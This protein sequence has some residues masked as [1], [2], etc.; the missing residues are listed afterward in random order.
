MEHDVINDMIQEREARRSELE[1]QLNALDGEIRLLKEAKARQER[2]APGNKDDAPR[3]PAA[4]AASK[5]SRNLKPMWADVMREIGRRGSAS[6]DE[7]DVHNREQGHNIKRGTL[8]SQLSI[9]VS[10][11]WLERNDSEYRLTASGAE[12]CDFTPAVTLGSTNHL[13]EK[14]EAPAD[15]GASSKE[16]PDELFG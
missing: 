16:Q 2:S 1:A 7:L 4:D 11:G 6:V 12:K 3:K 13:Q 9:Y 15:S 10:R 8:R 14:D 5:R